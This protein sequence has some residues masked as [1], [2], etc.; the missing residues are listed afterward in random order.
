MYRLLK[1]LPLRVKLLSGMA[2]AVLLICLFIY[3]YY[4]ERQRQQS[5]T[6]TETK[7]Q[8]MAEMVA[9]GVGI[10]LESGNYNAIMEAMRWAKRDSSLAYIMLFDTSGADFAAFKPDNVKIKASE[11]L[12]AAKSFEAGGVLHAHTDI[13][14]RGVNYGKVLLGYSLQPLYDETNRNRQTTALIS[15]ILFAMGLLVSYALS[16]A[17]LRPVNVL[18]VAAKRVANGERDIQVKVKSQDELGVLARAFNEMISKIQQSMDESRDRDWIKTAR[19][20]L[21]DLI[22]GDFSIEDLASRVND[23]MVKKLGAPVAAIYLM[24]DCDSESLDKQKIHRVATWGLN[25]PQKADIYLSSNDGLIAEVVR[26]AG[27]LVLENLPEGFYNIRTGV[28]SAP[29]TQVHLYPLI[30]NDEVVGVFE[31]A[32]FRE[33]SQLEEDFL[34]QAIEILGAAFNS[35]RSRCRLNLLLD[36]TREQAKKLRQ[37][38]EELQRNN[39]EL[40]AKAA[41]R[42]KLIK[43]LSEANEAAKDATKAKSE[44][45]ANMSH[46]I[47][48][49]MNGVIGMTSLLMDTK[50]TSEQMEYVQTIQTSSE[51]L[52]TII[53]DILDFSKIE[54]GKLEL[55]RQPFNVRQCVEDSIDLMVPKAEENEV[56]LAYE[57]D[58]GVPDMLEGDITRVR[59]ILVNLLSNAVKFTRQGDVVISVTGS[60]ISD[61]QFEVCFAVRD[62]GI[63][64]PKDRLDRLFHAFSQVDASTTRK[65]GGTG[66]GL[67][68][69]KRLAELMGG[70]IWVESEAGKG[71]TFSF[72][73]IAGYRQK[74][75]KNT[76]SRSPEIL[77]NKNV[78][79]VDDNSTNRRV[80][81]LQIGNWGMTF[82]QAENGKQALELLESGQTFDLAILDM[83]MPEMDGL[84]LGGKIREKYSLPLVMLT[85]LSRRDSDLKQSKGLFAAYLL[86]PVKQAQLQETL[87]RIFDKSYS[88]QPPEKHESSFDGEMSDR[89]PLKILL[90]EDNVV[91]QK[92]AQRLLD[93]MGY[94]VDIVGNGLEALEAIERRKY[95]VVFM[96]VQMPEMDGL[97]A[98]REI[99]KRWRNSEKRPHIVAMTANAMQGDREMCEKAG[100]DDY[101]SKPVQIKE[102]I[103]AL[104]KCPSHK[105]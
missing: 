27:P 21:N 32:G 33:F 45:L 19:A 15:F 43:K 50:L 87:I 3:S 24:E 34:K 86:K 74:V 5:I 98:S 26:K 44:F 14:Y 62:S 89:H 36:K 99:N 49:P 73:I 53:N 52:L 17:L 55:E 75:E 20:E 54:S 35:A 48:T 91:N 84:S 83:Q 102:L 67:A 28:G 76:G 104:E 64:I 103:N 88:T 81:S 72:S 59:Q 65:Y 92:V 79:I 94:R 71:S 80:L 31:I 93:K 40:E 90:A 41:E 22:R 29:A 7:V 11:A 100:M 97:A 30:N 105:S 63:G 37:Q 12:K 68:I 4:P 51:A 2:A 10:G 101:I 57:I 60:R 9:L 42:E 38:Q 61:N 47:R 70:R 69:C 58:I 77:K 13:V 95:D 85:S 82:A 6:A 25:D 18:F 23:Y 96:D 39:N 8:S 1:K 56:N 78:L 66:L 16:S 46:E